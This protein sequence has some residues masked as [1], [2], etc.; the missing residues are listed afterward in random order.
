ME[1]FPPMILKLA[2]RNIVGNGWRSLINIIILSIL[3]MGM[4]WMESM[5]HSWISIA[6]TQQHDYEYVAGLARVKGYDPFDAF[7]WDTAYAQYPERI[8]NLIAQGRAVPVLFS[9]AAI[10]HDGRMLA[11]VAK[12]IPAS[13]TLLKLPT[14]LLQSNA[15]GYAKAI[16]GP[17]M[18]RTS[19]LRKGDVFTLRVKD[20]FGAFNTLDL[21]VA[22]IAHIPVPALD[23]GTVWMDMEAL[24]TLRQ[25]PVCATTIAFADAKQAAQP[26]QGFQYLDEKEYFRDLDAIMKNENM[27]KYVMYGLII[28]LA[29]IAIFDTQALAVFRRRKEIGTLTAL[30]MPRPSIIMLFTVEGALYAVGAIL[31]SG[32]LGLP[33]FLYFGLHGWDIPSGY[34]EFGIAGFSETI[35][36]SYPLP[37]VLGVLAWVIGITVLVSWLPARRITNMKPTDALKGK[38]G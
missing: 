23:T 31:L 18:A 37:M 20:R 8:Q 14:A 16:I 19:R 13:Q 36:F 24:A 26:L 38:V 32:I 30:G 21:E 3:C 22:D 34:S 7:S 1:G 2:Y 10:Y 25:L 35:K 15:P 12:G 4:L 28:F 27:G 11:V 9:P 29:M 33:L 17:T 5:Y 6:R